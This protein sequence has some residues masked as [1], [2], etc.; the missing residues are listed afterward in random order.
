MDLPTWSRRKTKKRP[1]G[2]KDDA[3]QGSVRRAG[4][5]AAARMPVVIGAI[6]LVVG[7]VIAVVAMREQ[8]KEARANTTKILAEAVGYQA[9]AQLIDPEQVGKVDP[10][11]PV[12]ES[13]AQRAEKVDEVLADL[14]K[15][16]GGSEADVNADLVRAARLMRTAKH[17]EAAELYRKF[18]AAVD[19]SHPMRFVALEGL[20]LALEAQGSLE[21]ALQQF[22]RLAGEEK[23]FYRDMALA[24]QGR[25][26]E[27]LERTD[28]AIAVYRKYH[29]EYPVNTGNNFARETVKQRLE[30]LAPDAL[31]APAPDADATKSEAPAN[32]GE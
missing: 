16:A 31:T 8:G 14:A 5:A 23:A 9:R 20:G 15:K 6:V 29:K 28:E 7:G 19:E 12:V 24:H 25:V 17:A 18:L 4:K 2:D 27:A 32:A 30:E 22:E 26:L 21:D 1:Q 11:W 3:F 10:P 13:E